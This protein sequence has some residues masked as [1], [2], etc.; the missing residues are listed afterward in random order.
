MLYYGI[1]HKVG[2]VGVLYPQ[3]KTAVYLLWL[4]RHNSGHTKQ[5]FGEQKVRRFL[6]SQATKKT[7]RVVSSSSVQ[8][9]GL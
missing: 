9:H 8:A 4:M 6:S 5:M 2:A 7:I 3:A 1:D